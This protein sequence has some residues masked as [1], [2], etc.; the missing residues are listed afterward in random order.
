MTLIDDV[1]EFCKLSPH[2]RKWVL[3]QLFDLRRVV[4]RDFKNDQQRLE[5]FDV[6]IKALDALH[7]LAKLG[8]LVEES[9]ED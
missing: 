9:K 6:T 3:S 1:Q 5:D 7:H 2:R 4:V 8:I